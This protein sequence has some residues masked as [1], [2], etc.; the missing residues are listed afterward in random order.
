MLKTQPIDSTPTS[1]PT[2]RI[3]TGAR[4]NAV[5][6]V[7]P[8]ASQKSNGPRPAASLSASPSPGNIDARLFEVR[9]LVY[10][11]GLQALRLLDL[12]TKVAEDSVRI[13]SELD[14]IRDELRKRG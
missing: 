10:Q 1:A 2:L 8:A 14:A 5:D 3:A 4:L 6:S 12:S 7:S 11:R 13:C 9:L